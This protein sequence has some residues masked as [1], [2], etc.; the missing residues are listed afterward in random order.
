[1]TGRLSIERSAACQQSSSVRDRFGAL[2]FVKSLHN[3]SKS[4]IQVKNGSPRC[5]RIVARV[6]RVRGWHRLQDDVHGFS[7]PAANL[8]RKRPLLSAGP[9][10]VTRLVLASNLSRNP[11]SRSV[12]TWLFRT[13]SCPRVQDS[14]RPIGAGRRKPL[15]RYA[16][17][18]RDSRKA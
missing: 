13:P 5:Q 16:T 7:R 6:F 12:F 1:M 9:L 4:T 10:F 2:A 3:I 18:G 8:Q 17:R 15:R 14:R 11:V